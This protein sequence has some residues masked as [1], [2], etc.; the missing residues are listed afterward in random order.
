MTEFD[1]TLKS[2]IAKVQEM[3]ASYYAKEFPKSQPPKL[4]SMEGPKFVRIVK[5]GPAER[6]VYCFVEKAT[7]AILKADGWKR[8][9]KGARGSIYGADPLSGVGPWGAFYL[10]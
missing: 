7:G 10:R 3:M 2:F 6:S 4:A 8:P 5:V 1:T 9:A